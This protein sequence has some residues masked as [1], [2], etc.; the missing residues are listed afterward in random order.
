M[1]V[2][3]AT[4]QN[5]DFIYRVPAVVPGGP[6]PL[7][8]QHIPVGQQVQIAGGELDQETIDGIIQ[9]H[10]RYGLVASS[11]VEHVRE[12]VG[13]VYAVGPKPIAEAKIR[14]LMMH[15][16]GMLQ[17]RGK[18][19]RKEAAVAGNEIIANNLHESGFP[20]DLKTLEVSMSED[21]HDDRDEQPAIS[22]GYRI[23]GTANGAVPPIP[24]RRGPGRPRRP[25]ADLNV[26]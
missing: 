19:F 18:R 16:T 12:F 11:E 8:T 13:L 20:A 25:A 1:F 2:G 24:P 10:A 3:N 4:K 14:H 9:Q 22:E 5:F 23:G 21:N 7:R 15:N 17:I 26:R 6:M